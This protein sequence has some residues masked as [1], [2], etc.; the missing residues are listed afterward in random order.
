M[1]T[2]NTKQE[3]NFMVRRVHHQKRSVSWV[4]SVLRQFLPNDSFSSSLVFLYNSMSL[5]EEIKKCSPR[6]VDPLQIWCNPEGRENCC[7]EEPNPKD[8]T[9]TPLQ[10]HLLVAHFFF[11][12]LSKFL[13]WNYWFNPVIKSS[14]GNAFIFLVFLVSLNFCNIFGI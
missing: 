1:L 3:Q 11:F 13:L 12:F 8:V 9:M 2:K 6:N 10:L 7:E 5:I 14:F 4:N